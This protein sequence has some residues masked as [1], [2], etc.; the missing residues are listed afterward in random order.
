MV[1]KLRGGVLFIEMCLLSEN[2]KAL[3]L[4]QGHYVEITPTR[5]YYIVYAN[6]AR[7]FKFIEVIAKHY[8]IELI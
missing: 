4:K 3:I 1:I 8:S 6:P 7:L 5:N 2:Q